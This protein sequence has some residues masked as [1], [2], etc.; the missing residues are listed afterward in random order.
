MKPSPSGSR[1]MNAGR[2]DCRRSAAA[3]AIFSPIT[4]TGFSWKEPR[5]VRLRWR[6]LIAHALGAIELTGESG[7]LKGWK[8][9]SDARCEGVEPGFSILDPKTDSARPWITSTRT[10]GLVRMAMVGCTF[11]D[12]PTTCS[13]TWLKFWGALACVRGLKSQQVARIAGTHPHL[14]VDYASGDRSQRNST[15]RNRRSRQRRRR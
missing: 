3:V 13:P 1:V 8:A 4:Q 2:S 14:P 11:S 7:E 6:N 9:I 12:R 15:R 10:G 5:N